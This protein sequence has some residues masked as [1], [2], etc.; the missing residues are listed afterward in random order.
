MITTRNYEEL[1]TL[2][3]GTEEIL[4]IKWVLRE[5]SVEAAAFVWLGFFTLFYQ[6]VA[7]IPVQK[8][9]CIFHA[10]GRARFWHDRADHEVH[11]CAL[12]I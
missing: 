8:Q 5:R 1:H 10:H 2:F 11:R 12:G 6:K 7:F 9:L 4:Q 3:E